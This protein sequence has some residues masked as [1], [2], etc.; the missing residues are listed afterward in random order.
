MIPKI[1]HYCWFGRKK[2]PESFY[3]CLRSWHRYMPDYKIKEWNEDNFDVNSTVY[4]REAYAT[5]N[6]AFV[7]DV[8]RVYALWT[9]GGVYLDTDIEICASTDSLLDT[10]NGFVGKETHQLIGT[11]VMASEPWA[12]WVD[13]FLDYYRQTHFI[14]IFGH[15]NKIPNTKILTYRILPQIEPT[16]RPEVF[17]LGYISGI[18]WEDK[19]PTHLT[20]HTF[21][22]HRYTASWRRKLALREKVRLLFQ[23][24]GI[25]Y[26]WNR[27]R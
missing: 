9:E 21:A 20:R 10:P 24:A 4:S 8:C 12:I 11:G 1:I 14:N 26:G 25:R 18:N 7:S 17:P 5:G 3:N 22:I 23:G 13:V 2:K 15:E 27:S 6:M 16:F 19:K